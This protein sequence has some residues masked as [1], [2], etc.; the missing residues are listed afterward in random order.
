M[1]NIIKLT[2]MN[3]KV[4]LL[5]LS[6]LLFSCK[7]KD[8]YWDLTDEEKS[9]LP[10]D[11]G[12]PVRFKT[13]KN[14]TIDYIVDSVS[15]QYE[16]YGRKRIIGKGDLYTQV[17]RFYFISGDS[18]FLNIALN[19]GEPNNFAVIYIDKG[20]IGEIYG[21]DFYFS[22]IEDSLIIN[23]VSYSNVYIFHYASSTD[24]LYIQPDKGIL[25]IE[26]YDNLF[27]LIE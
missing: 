10:Y 2:E 1:N 25:K 18:S 24:G 5:F 12:D 15:L 19:S 11:I 20:F 27:E 7:E 3:K 22:R 14:D 21:T 6:L 8:V 26:Y 17:L 9:L 13:G 4:F 16:Y 23:D